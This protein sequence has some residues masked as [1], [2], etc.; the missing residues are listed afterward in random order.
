MFHR[1][2]FIKAIILGMSLDGFLVNL[3]THH[4][5][6]AEFPPD[7]L[8]WHLVQ[9]LD[10]VGDVSELEVSGEAE[11]YI[12]GSEVPPYPDMKKKTLTKQTND[13]EL[14]PKSKRPTKF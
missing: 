5:N 11:S 10:A 6:Q 4:P 12:T 14:W 7:R 13:T 1:C 2:F 8:C 3:F 9:S